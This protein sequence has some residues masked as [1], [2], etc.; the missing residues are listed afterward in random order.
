MPF[1]LFE[2]LEHFKI[3]TFFIKLNQFETIGSINKKF[4]SAGR[5]DNQITFTKLEVNHTFLLTFTILLVNS[6]VCLFLAKF[7]N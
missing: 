4:Y 5:T 3:D 1:K 2:L 7:I 6:G